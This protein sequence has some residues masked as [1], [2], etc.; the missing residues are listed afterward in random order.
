MSFFRATLVKSDVA[1]DVPWTFSQQREKPTS[2]I[3]GCHEVASET[4]PKG[5][6]LVAQQVPRLVTLGAMTCT[7]A[8]GTN[9]QLPSD[10]VKHAS[11]H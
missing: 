5:H 10:L 4:L 11:W 8:Q 7:S 9:H 3:H 2:E 1:S 6:T